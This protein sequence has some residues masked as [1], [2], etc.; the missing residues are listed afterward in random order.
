MV[1]LQLG[2]CFVSVAFLIL[3][4]HA[5]NPTRL[6]TLE[7]VNGTLVKCKGLAKRLQ[8]SHR[9]PWPEDANSGHISRCFKSL[10]RQASGKTLRFRL[11]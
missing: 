2:V 3:Q 5:S 6:S 1:L 4:C 7:Q 11:A 8:H 9:T 10:W